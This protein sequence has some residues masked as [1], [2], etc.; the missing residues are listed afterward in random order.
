MER[1]NMSAHAYDRILKVARTI[2]DL[3][4]TADILDHRNR[5]AHQ[6]HPQPRPPHRHGQF[7]IMQKNWSTTSD[8]R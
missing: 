5:G 7:P 2:T 6:P 4:G 1:M 8:F 3:E